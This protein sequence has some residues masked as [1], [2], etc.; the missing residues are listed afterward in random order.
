MRYIFPLGLICSDSE[1]VLKKLS[2]QVVSLTY[3]ETLNFS[4]FGTVC[5]QLSTGR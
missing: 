1:M 5:T 4:V 2:Y 3:Y